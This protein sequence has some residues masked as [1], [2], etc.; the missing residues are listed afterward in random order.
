MAFRVIQNH[1]NKASIQQNIILL[2]VM[3]RIKRKRSTKSVY[4]R[5]IELNNL[6][7]R[8]EIGYDVEPC[9]F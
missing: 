7:K 8:F 2:K 3:D 5:S 9:L 4:L 1:H 6:D